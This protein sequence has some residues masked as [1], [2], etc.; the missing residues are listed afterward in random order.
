M[1]SVYEI[2]AC[3]QLNQSYTFETEQFSIISGQKTFKSELNVKW[4]KTKT[5]KYRL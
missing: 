3:T 4:Q 2:Y 1:L 5:Y